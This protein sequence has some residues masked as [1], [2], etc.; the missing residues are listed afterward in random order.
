MKDETYFFHQSPKE[1]AKDICSNIEWNDNNIVLEP[2]AGENSFYDAIPNEIT[3]YRTEIE[4]GLCFKQFDYIG[5]GVN[6][7]ISNPPFKLNGRNAFFDIVMF[8]SKIR[9]ISKIIFLCSDICFGSLTP[10]RMMKINEEGMFI[11]KLDT[12]CI[13]RWKGRYRII[14]FERTYNNSFNYYLNM[15]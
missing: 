12:C 6:T 3:K 11:T 13:K 2:F 10:K 9:S 4:D 5:T 8:F 1:L 14:T 7:I 15:Y